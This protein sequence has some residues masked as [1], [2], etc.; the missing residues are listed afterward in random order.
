VKPWTVAV[1][2]RLVPDSELLEGS[3]E[4]HQRTLDH[5]RLETAPAEPPS[6]RTR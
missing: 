4:S 1:P 6:P 5:R 3:C 2:F